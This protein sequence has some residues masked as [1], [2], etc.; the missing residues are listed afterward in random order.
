MKLRN[1]REVRMLV[2]SLALELDPGE[3]ATVRAGDLPDGFAADAPPAGRKKKTPSTEPQPAEGEPAHE[4]D[5]E[6]D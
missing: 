2:P 4:T 1:D 6:N 5:K 3:E